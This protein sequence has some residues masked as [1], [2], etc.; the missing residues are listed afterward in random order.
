MP[1]SYAGARVLLVAKFSRRY[2]HTGGALR[3]ALR[4]LG[5][6]VATVEE[7]GRLLDALLRRTLA[8]RM[9]R[10]LRR[11]RPDL[12]LVFKGERLPPELITRLRG[13]TP[14]RW[15]NWFPDDPHRAD[16]S[17]GLSPSYDAFFTHDSSMVA[18]HT[19]A[20]GRAHYLPFGVDAVRF[21]PVSP[22]AAWRAAVT[23]VGTRD[24]ERDAAARALEPLGFRA[25]GPG[26]AERAVYGEEYRF[27]LSGGSVAL[28]IHRHFGVPAMAER[29]G[30]GANMRLFELA[31]LGRPQLVDAKA[32]VARHFRPGEE[33]VLYRTL[34]ELAA[35]AAEL[36]ADPARRESLGRAARR[37]AAAEHTWDHRMAELLSVALA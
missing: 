10:A 35:L 23:F 4:R 5:C 12:V 11:H 3:D 17:L 13:L 26:W 37:R 6:E 33:V 36:L 32:D 8:D 15:A 22:P 2:H 1:G 16:L 14:A 7:R 29:Y 18:R 24:P 19:A 20:G 9:G 34:A 21:A 27:A 30:T 28:N 31:A 25:W